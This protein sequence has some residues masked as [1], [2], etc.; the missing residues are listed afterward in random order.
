MMHMK[1]ELFDMS[2]V[3][4]ISEE[5]GIHDVIMLEERIFIISWFRW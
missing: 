1:R 3:L 5:R 2:M 4:L